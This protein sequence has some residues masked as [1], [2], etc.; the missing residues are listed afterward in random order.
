MRLLFNTDPDDD[1]RIILGIINGVAKNSCSSNLDVSDSKLLSLIK[2]LRI[3][4]PHNDGIENA[5][6]FKKVAMFVASFCA[7]RPVLGK[8]DKIDQ[9][10]IFNGIPQYENALIALLIGVNALL[11]AEI[12]RDGNTIILAQPITM[13]LH[14]LVDVVDALISATPV[15][16]FKLLTIFLEQLC[17]KTNPDAQYPSF[18]VSRLIT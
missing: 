5:S 17:Y 3:D 18:P 10:S 2:Y 16:S 12:R 15:A 4:F 8:L 14:S 1:V 9:L 11:G 6:V 13:S 7:E